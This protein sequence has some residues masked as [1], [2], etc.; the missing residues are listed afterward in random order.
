M[1]CEEV[2]SPIFLTAGSAAVGCA[3][4]AAQ[5]ALQAPSS[6]PAR[7]SS[8]WPAGFL[9]A[10]SILAVF[11]LSSLHSAH[12]PGARVLLLRT[13][14]RGA[15]DQVEADFP[16]AAGQTAETFASSHRAASHPPRP[17]RDVRE[18]REGAPS[19][20]DSPSLRAAHGCGRMSNFSPSPSSDPAGVF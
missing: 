10:P 13:S 9:L 11:C 5:G 15:G 17:G 20:R 14:A 16:A 2:L 12:L 3:R 6:G 7:R 18:R 4:R 1:L 8:I 19:R